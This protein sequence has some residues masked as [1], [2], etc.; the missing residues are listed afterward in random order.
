MGHRPPV[1]GGYFPRSRGFAAGH[2]A[3]AMFLA[4]A[5]QASKSIVQTNESRPRA[6]RDRHEFSRLVKRPTGCRSSDS[7][8]TNVALSFTPERHLSC[9]ARRRDNARDARAQSI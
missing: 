4:L 1:K 9:E 3:R 2:R 8:C 7:P 6:M 5:E